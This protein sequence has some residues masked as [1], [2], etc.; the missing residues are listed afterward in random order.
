MQQQQY[1]HTA[2]GEE[3]NREPKLSEYNLP[4]AEVNKY[5]TI[6]VAVDTWY[7]NYLRNNYFKN[8]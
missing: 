4:S 5:V 7:L 3:R 2:I 6:F 1:Q 8:I